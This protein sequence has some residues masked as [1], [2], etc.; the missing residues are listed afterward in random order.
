MNNEGCFEEIYREGRRA[1]VSGKPFEERAHDD[2][3][4]NEA[5]QQGWADAREEAH[6]DK[7]N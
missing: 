5:W 3:R 2:E 7:S 6:A 4:S 1:F